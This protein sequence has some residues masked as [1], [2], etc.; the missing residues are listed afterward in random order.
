VQQVTSAIPGSTGQILDGQDHGAADEIL[1]PVL[2]A[3]FA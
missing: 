1:A 3:F 2:A